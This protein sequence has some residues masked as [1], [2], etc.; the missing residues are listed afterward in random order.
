MKSD[1]KA[2]RSTDPGSAVDPF[3]SVIVPVY[4]DAR[5]LGSCLAA[6]EQQ[7][8][9]S[10]RYEII[11]I[12][13]GSDPEEDITDL[14]HSFDHVSLTQERIP[15]SYAARNKGL[16]LA[17]GEIIAFT[18]S[19]C[20][21]KPDWLEHGVQHLTTNPGCGLVAGR[22]DMF[23]R[24]P[25]R[26]TVIEMYDQVVMGFPQELLIATHKIAMTANVFTRRHIIEEVGNFRSDLRSAG[27]GEWA[28]RVYKA[29]YEHHYVAQACVG[30]P[31]RD[32]FEAL[33][34]RVTRYTGGKVDRFITH[35]PSWWKRHRR[36][37]RFIVEDLT[38]HAFTQSRKVCQ[39]GRIDT[40]GMRLKV[41]GLVA[42]MQLLSASEVV[43]L[44]LGGQ[45]RR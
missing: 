38:I 8:Y 43:R 42:V 9:P 15:G 28:Q 22:I 5:R 7:T 27:D 3:V 35:E 16:T 24:Q 30:H 14:A 31:A 41:L 25:E 32:T 29:G 39:D 17:K 20:I 13:N 44:K 2:V 11:V 6:L 12:D 33:T 34:T 18:D 1:P 36:F 26:A 19:D 37:V 40:I 4:N 23:A 10:H 21:P 45:S